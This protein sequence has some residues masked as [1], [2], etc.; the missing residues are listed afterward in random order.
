M[1][2]TTTYHIHPNNTYVEYEDVDGVG[3]NESS[4]SS[5]RGT[6]TREGSTYTLGENVARIQIDAPKAS[7]VCGRKVL[8]GTAKWIE[9]KS[10][11]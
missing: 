10:S 9:P 4:L 2:C 8:E 3:D 7:I 6:Y 11:K 1:T 5:S